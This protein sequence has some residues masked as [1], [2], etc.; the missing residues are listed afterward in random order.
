MF[1]DQVRG[2]LS[3]GGVSRRGKAL[4]ASLDIAH[5]TGLTSR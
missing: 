2:A 1:T 5:A 3:K 4:D